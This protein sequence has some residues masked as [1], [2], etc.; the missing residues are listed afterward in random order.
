MNP[1]PLS[2]LEI[3]DLEFQVFSQPLKYSLFRTCVVY[4]DTWDTVSDPTSPILSFDLEIASLDLRMYGALVTDRYDDNISHV[5]C[6]PSSHPD[7]VS[8]WRAR[9]RLRY[10]KFHLV[11][12]SWISA[13]VAKGIMVD[14]MAHIPV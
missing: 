5:V 12:L 8:E 2:N 10:T 1:E 9:N 4:V 6:H 13:S 3:A 14:E 7:R 11:D